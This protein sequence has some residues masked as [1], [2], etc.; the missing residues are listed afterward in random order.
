MLI[1]S[2]MCSFFNGRQNT[3]LTTHNQ[4]AGAHCIASW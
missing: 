2:L 1:A 3:T 4:H